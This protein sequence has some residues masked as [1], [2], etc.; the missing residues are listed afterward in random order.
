[1][2]QKVK[3]QTFPPDPSEMKFS[4]L[5]TSYAVQFVL[6]QIKLME[7]VQVITGKNGQYIVQ[8]SEGAK[9]VTSMTCSRTF[10]HSMSLPCRHIFAQRRKLK[11]PLFDAD[12]YNK[13]LTS[14]YYRT[15]QRLLQVLRRSL[16][17]FPLY[18][19]SRSEN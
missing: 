10:C 17:Y 6:Q 14:A 15:T 7:K 5:L 4:K 1:M 9:V 13:S 19:K 11:C 16:Y 12:M 2:F 8:T 3:V 18:Q